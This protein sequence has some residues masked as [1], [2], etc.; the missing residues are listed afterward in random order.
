MGESSPEPEK[1]F[2]DLLSPAAVSEWGLPRI[3]GRRVIKRKLFGRITAYIRSS[4]KGARNEEMQELD[5]ASTSSFLLWLS[6]ERSAFDTSKKPHSKHLN[7][8]KTFDFVKISTNKSS[9]TEEFTDLTDDGDVESNNDTFSGGFRDD[10]LSKDS[11]IP[12]QNVSEEYVRSCIVNDRCALLEQSLDLIATKKISG[13]E[14]GDTSVAKVLLA[15]YGSLHH[16]LCFVRTMLKWVPFLTQDCGDSELWR[17]IFIER[18]CKSSSSCHFDVLL[19][20][21]CNCAMRWSNEHIAAC[22]SWILSQQSKSSISGSIYSLK[23]S[24]RFLV[25]S[26]EQKSIHCFDFDNDA[27]IPHFAYVQTQE[28]ALSA[29]NLALGCLESENIPTD[30]MGDLLENQTMKEPADTFIGRNIFPDWLVILFLIAKSGKPY[31][32]MTIK[33]ILECIDENPRRALYAVLLRLYSMF[34]LMINLGEPR[35]KNALLQASKDDSFPWLE[36][37]CPLDSQVSEMLSN[38]TKSPHQRLLQSIMDIAKNHPLILVRHLHVVSQKLL[39]DGSGVDSDHQT[40]IKRGRIQ[41]QAPEGDAVA[42]IGSRTVK[43]SIVQWG[44]SFNE[45]VWTSVIDILESLPGEVVFTCGLKTGLEGI[46]E[47]YLKLFLT[48]VLVLGSEGNISRIRSKFVKLLN[49][50]KSSKPK[51]FEN[52]AQQNVAG[53]GKTQDLISLSGMG[54]LFAAPVHSLLE[55]MKYGF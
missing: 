2:R 21:V 24:L 53:W 18:L 8:N 20:L 45:P 27:H 10:V 40:L 31:L 52:W 1:V 28:R 17:L 29:I 55:K 16:N 37:R 25:I 13:K 41:G 5:E 39:D 11:L 30:R 4:R 32:E 15:S 54:S 47:A 12:S 33:H 7:S 51:S 19:S 35:L 50:F 46:F 49:S 43:V 26:S 6:S 9:E 3:G 23:A 38:V 48:H 42:M 22:Q 34:P 44:F 36:W 14:Y